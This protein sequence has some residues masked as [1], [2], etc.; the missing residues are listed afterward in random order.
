MRRP[1]PSGPGW[2]SA[3]LVAVVAVQLCTS[4]ALRAQNPVQT[5]VA[6]VATA[7]PWAGDAIYQTT[8]LHRIHVSLSAAEWAVL[9]TSSARGGAAGGVTGGSDFRNADGRLIHVGSGFGGYFPW[10]HADIRIADAG[11][12]M[13]FKDV[14]LRYKGNLSF[15]SSSAAAPLF[16]N[17]KLKLDVHGTKGTWDGE[18][19]FNL[20]AGVI[21]TSKMRD[22]I[23]YATFRGAGVPAPRTAFVELIVTVPGLYQDAQAGLFTLVEDVNKKFLE[24]VLPPGTGLLMKPEGLRGG[25]QSLGDSWASYRTPLRPDREATPHEQQR[26]IEFA[27]LIS[28]SDVALFRAKIGT[29]LD[30]EQFLRFIAVHAMI[31]NTDSYLRGS[32]NFYL[33]LDPK[34]D[35]VRF[36]PWDQ[37]LSMG[38]RPGRGGAGPDFDVMRPISGD[39]PLIHWLL[40]DPA[41]AARYR[42]IVRELATTVFTAG[43]LSKMMDTLET[44]GT[45][46]GPAPREFLTSRT[47]YLQQL[48]AGWDRK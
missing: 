29:Y 31:V 42:T 32:H 5:P 6:S 47:A 17:F 9:Q 30:V 38:S 16:A 44:V 36:I 33:Y 20:H 2:A 19:T 8:K 39:Q 7:G 28:Q 25:I 22:A 34:D 41:V 10:A 1:S 43:E 11:G 37:D 27:R 26:L 21:D 14:G 18:K 12:G 4:L 3:A 13:A 35:K 24:R 40:D 15:S 46:R 23:A 45:G 48:I